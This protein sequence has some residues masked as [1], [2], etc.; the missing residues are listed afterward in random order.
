MAEP[1]DEVLADLMSDAGDVT[2][3]GN[4]AEYARAGQVFASRSGSNV[5]ELLL[6]EEIAEAA[7]R[8]PETGTSSRG[9]DWVRFA[10]SEWDDNAHDRLEAWFRVAWRLAGG[11]P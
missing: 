10:P 3:A 1:I 4:G 6:G 8:T 7:Q 2:V 9:V 11:R 5:V